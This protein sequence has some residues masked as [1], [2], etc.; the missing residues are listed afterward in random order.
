MLLALLVVTFVFTSVGPY[1]LSESM[2]QV[3]APLTLVLC[4]VLMN[5]NAVAVGLV[6][7]PFAFENVSVDMPEFAPS[8]GLIEFPVAFVLGPVLPLLAPVAMLHVSVPLTDICRPIFELDLVPLLQLRFVN[9]FH[10]HSVYSLVSTSLSENLPK[11]KFCPSIS[12][13]ISF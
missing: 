12:I 7:D 11:L 13:I 1:L 9:F 5:V 6:V 3:V 10:L 4:S 8:A 2:L